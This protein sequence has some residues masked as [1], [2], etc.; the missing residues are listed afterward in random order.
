MLSSVIVAKIEIGWENTV[1]GSQNSENIHGFSIT[2][3]RLT[4]QGQSH[5][6][7]IH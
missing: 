4:K 6:I 1:S 7:K 2:E 3:A 5:G